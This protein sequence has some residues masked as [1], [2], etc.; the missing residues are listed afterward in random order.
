MLVRNEPLATIV[1]EALEGFAAGRFETQVEVKRFLEGFPAFPKDA[2]TGAVHNQRVHD[3][4][5]RPIYA[6]YIEVPNWNV[7][8][9]RGQHQGLIDWATF[10][11]TQDRLASGAKAPARKDISADFPL[12]GFV[13]CGDCNK[14]LTAC[15]SKSKTG[16]K[17]PYY[18]CPT[19]GCDSYRKSIR[20]DDLEGEFTDVLQQMRPTASLFDLARR[21]FKDAWQQRQA[22]SDALNN[23]AEQEL[24]K[25][26]KQIEGLL[27]RIVDA[28]TAS[29]IKAYETRIA[30][31]ER[32]K[33]AISEQ[34]A[35]T[36]AP[37][38]SLDE[39][40]ELAMS[41]LK[42]PSKLWDS[43]QLTLRRT[44]LRLA[45]C[46]QITYCRKTGLRTPKTA[47]LFKLLESFSMHQLAMARPGGLEPPTLSLEG[48]CSVRLS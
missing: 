45:F 41:F 6:G 23:N 30:K 24:A 15:W 48:S 7:S 36:G 5:T 11:R 9:R 21:M 40:F 37:R 25:I 2:S 22:Q 29:V 35:K 14:P 31:L 28:S 42:N 46:E 26:D 47:L 27:D 8:L 34:L 13:L 43:G 1:Q 19:K 38:R 44:V 17:H 16:K 4:L 33:L 3:I 12:R 10:Q 20:R 18:L 39:L 32:D